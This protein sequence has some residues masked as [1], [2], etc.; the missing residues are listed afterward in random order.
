VSQEGPWGGVGN[1]ALWGEQAARANQA[2]L[3]KLAQS[4]ESLPESAI[5]DGPNS[6]DLRSAL[7][8]LEQL[9]VIRSTIDG[10][11]HP[12]PHYAITFGLLRSWLRRVQ[13][14]LEE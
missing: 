13:M 8:A 11:G 14:G 5:V 6:A 1:A 10:L 4:P 9:H 7:F 12:D 3:L 2:V